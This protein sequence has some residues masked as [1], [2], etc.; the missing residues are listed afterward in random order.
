M[1]ETSQ[2]EIDATGAERATL[3]FYL[4][5]KEIAEEV[6]R[7][8]DEKEI[9][10]LA[11]E[12]VRIKSPSENSLE[13]VCDDFHTMMRNLTPVSEREASDRFRKIAAGALG[14]EQARAILS[15][16]GVSEG[17]SLGAIRG[18]PAST[19][20]ELLQEEHPQVAAVI[21]AQLEREHA[22][23][24]LALVPLELQGELLGRIAQLEEIPEDLIEAASEALARALA[25]GSPSPSRKTKATAFD[26]ISFS[27][28]VLNELPSEESNR[29]LEQV[30]GKVQP[31]IK[32]A[33]FTF[34]DLLRIDK[35]GMQ[36]LMREI[37]TDVVLAALKNAS[38][39]LLDHFLGAVSKRAA[40]ALMEDLEVL[41]PMR[42]T[43]V[44]EARRNVVEVALRLGEE[45]KLMLPGGTEMM[46]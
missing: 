35:R 32:E 11:E 44:E 29:I 30:E 45:G 31:K 28:S 40:A 39:S 23:D 42:L 10:A 46:V 9:R 34:E 38:D 14:A 2:D 20:A 37:P 3:L 43:Q 41:P 18:T 16:G 26:G 6:L 13:R 8:L 25:L 19:L 24:V 36:V 7:H 27:A 5:D 15:S 33:M 4:L 21:V 1:N 17:D 22:A 12:S